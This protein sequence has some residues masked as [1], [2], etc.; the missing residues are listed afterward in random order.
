MHSA[1]CI[2]LTQNMASHYENKKLAIVNKYYFTAR[3]YGN[4]LLASYKNTKSI[5]KTMALA[6]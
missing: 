5:A 4:K 6:K 1:T 2:T 3:K